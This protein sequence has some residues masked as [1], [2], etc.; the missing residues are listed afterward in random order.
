MVFYKILA[1]VGTS[2]LPRDVSLVG[3]SL[4]NH[5]R[6]LPETPSEPV[7]P[8][9][10]QLPSHSPTALPGISSSASFCLRSRKGHSYVLRDSAGRW[11]VARPALRPQGV[12]CTCF[13][14]ALPISS[15]TETLHPLGLCPGM[16]EKRWESSSWVLQRQKSRLHLSS[17]ACAVPLRFP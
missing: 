2:H 14:R 10:P 11:A 17:L 7:I 4:Q 16:M 1:A 15:V 8:S 12:T 6:F 3:L 5:L 9:L 13:S